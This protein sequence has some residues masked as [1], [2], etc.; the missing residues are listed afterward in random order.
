MLRLPGSFTTSKSSS[1]AKCE[2]GL[3]ALQV[4]HYV[5]LFHWNMNIVACPCIWKN[6]FGLGTSYSNV[7]TVVVFLLGISVG[8]FWCGGFRS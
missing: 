1:D 7:T 5:D 3:L 4:I 8:F 6:Q 2:V